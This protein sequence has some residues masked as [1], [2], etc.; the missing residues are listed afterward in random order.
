MRVSTLKKLF[1]TAA[2]FCACATAFAQTAANGGTAEAAGAPLWAQLADAVGKNHFNLFATA[3][4]LL[5]IVHSFFYGEFLYLSNRIKVVGDHARNF[6]EVAI[7]FLRFLSEVEIVFALWLLPLFIGYVYYFGWESL[8]SYIDE[9]AYEKERFAEPVFVLVIMSIS[10]T[11]PIVDL[12]SKAIE[13]VARM[14][15]NTVRAWWCCILIVGSLAVRT[16]LQ[17]RAERKIQI[18]DAWLVA[19]IHINRWHPHPVCSPSGAHGKKTVGL[20]F[21]VHA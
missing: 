17:I 4:F 7:R 18:R 21:Y 20:G 15:G 3:M 8:V 5:A 9:M 6:R 1:A 2:I 12:A 11:R 10:A 14:W 16:L 13:V 19:C